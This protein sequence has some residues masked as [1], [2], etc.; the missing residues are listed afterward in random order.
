MR[1][2]HNAA[3]AQF[4]FS[5]IFCISIILL[6]VDHPLLI[7]CPANNNWWISQI[8]FI[9][10]FLFPLNNYIIS[11]L[12]GAFLELAKKVRSKWKVFLVSSQCQQP[13][14]KHFFQ[15]CRKSCYEVENCE[16]WTYAENDRQLCYLKSLDAISN[17]TKKAGVVS[18]TKRCPGEFHRDTPRLIKLSIWFQPLYTK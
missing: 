8:Y 9:Y 11:A 16:V 12:L 17:R 18:G 15:E 6:S 13:Q 14:K 7:S 2:L 5:A 3:N 10:F 1:V 4:C